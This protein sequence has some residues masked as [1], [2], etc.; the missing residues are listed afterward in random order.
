MTY[1]YT[2]PRMNFLLQEINLP[3]YT[4]EEIKPMIRELAIA[5]QAVIMKDSESYKQITIVLASYKEAT[6][7]TLNDLV[8]ILRET[9]DIYTSAQL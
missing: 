1:Q 8:D 2:I 3:D 5:L 4:D 7:D 6:G 9:L